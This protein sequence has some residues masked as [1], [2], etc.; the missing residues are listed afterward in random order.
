MKKIFWTEVITEI[1]RDRLSKNFSIIEIQ[2]TEGLA[3]PSPDHIKPGLEASIGNVCIHPPDLHEA[4]HIHLLVDLE[5]PTYLQI[6]DRHAHLR[7]GIRRGFLVGV[8]LGPKNALY[9]TGNYHQPR[10]AL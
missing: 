8:D 5:T 4:N 9:D 3:V 6:A 1:Q 2:V 10:P 7:V